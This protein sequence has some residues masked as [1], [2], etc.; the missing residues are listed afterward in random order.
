[1]ELQLK[2]IGMIKN[3]TIKLDGLTVIAGENNIGKSTIGKLLFSLIKSVHRYD[4]DLEEGKEDKVFS[5]LE[6]NYFEIRRNLNL[7]NNK[8]REKFHPARFRRDLIRYSKDAI[9][10]RVI[11]LENIKNTLD[12]EIYEK[13][14]NN[15][16]KIEKLYLEENDIEKAQKNAFQ[17]ALISEFK[18]KI[19]NAN[20]KELSLIKIDEGQNKIVDISIDKNKITEF[21]I[22]DELYF[23][24]AT[25]IETPIV[26]QLSESIQ[27]SRTYFEMLEDR[28][29][30][31]QRANVPLHIKDLNNKLKISLDEDSLFN[32][33]DLLNRYDVKKLLSI[34]S[35]VMSGKIKY[36]KEIRDYQYIDDNG[37]VFD[38]LN[39]AT[40]IKSFGI[41]QMLIKSGIIDQRSLLIVDEP[42]VH[43][44]PKWQLKYA[45]LIVELIKNDINVLVTS[46]SPYMIQALVKYARDAK[47]VDKSN[48]YL[49]QKEGLYSS[50]KNVNENLHKIFEL[51]AEP[52]NEV[53]E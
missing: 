3:S 2:N 6:K 28:R 34:V 33:E 40:G 42:E 4:E 47:I 20:S 29:S 35:S 19:S 37:K 13:I 25:F 21:K 15:L 23:S 38:S 36:N 11:L 10:E 31:I 43:L 1:M 8:L 17:K 14:R 12:I 24:D 39:T 46:H 50:V 49:A 44:H 16:L 52:M 32:V 53:Y 26:L 41:I 27:M 30:G 5:L 18:G 45:E 9:D 51:L 48:F 7:S 22:F